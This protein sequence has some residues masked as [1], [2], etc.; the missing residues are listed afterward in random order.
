MPRAADRFDG[1]PTDQS[2][3]RCTRC[4]A[5]AHPAGGLRAVAE[6]AAELAAA[7]VPCVVGVVVDTQGSTYRKRGALILLDATGM[8]AGALSGGCLES[9]V[10]EQRAQ[11]ARVTASR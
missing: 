2:W 11:R 7:G 1:R 8:R 3:R 9:E 6:T 4:N 5:A 10:E